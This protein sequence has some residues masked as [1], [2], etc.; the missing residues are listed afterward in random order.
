MTG[1]VRADVY[2]DGVLMASTA[3]EFYGG[4]TTVLSGLKIDWGRSTAVD[5]P[6]PSSL[7]LTFAQNQG[8]ADFLR[9]LAV[10]RRLDVTATALI[11]S[12][13]NQNTISGGD[14]EAPTVPPVATG[15]ATLELT[16]AQV[17]SGLQ[18]GLIRAVN[19]ALDAVMVFP[20]VPFSDDIT[21]W[22]AVPRMSSG[23][24]WSLGAWL[25][26]AWGTTVTVEPVLFSDPTGNYTRP[27]PS[28]TLTIQRTTT[29]TNL[30]TNPA[31]ATITGWVGPYPALGHLSNGLVC[32]QMVS[33]GLATPY[34][35]S[36]TAAPAALAGETYT[37]SALV[38]VVGDVAGAQY[39]FRAHTTPANTYFPSGA[40]TLT[41]GAGPNLQRVT[42]TS[43]INADTPAGTLNFSMVRSGTGAAGIQ[44]RMAQLT[45]EK[46][47][48]GGPYFDGN[49]PDSGGFRY[50]WTGAENASSSIQFTGA[51]EGW[52]EFVTPIPT[53]D[54]AWAGVM[55]TVHQIGPAWT[56]VS[57]SWSDQGATRRW[58][59]S[60][61]AYV[62]D[63][64]VLAP[65][66]GTVRSVLAFRGRV[67]DMEAKWV[68]TLAGGTTQV[69]VTAKDFTADLANNRIGDVPWL[70][71]A[72][73][74][75]VAR[76]LELA[77]TGV[78]AS[79]DASISS[80]PVSYRDVDSQ[81]AADLVT[82][83]AASVAAVAWPVVHDPG[84]ESYWVEDPRNR[85]PLYMLH[86]NTSTGQAEVVPNPVAPE[87]IGLTSSN[88]LEE[89][90][91]WTQDVADV[92]TRV[93]VTWLEQGVDED[94][95][96]ETTE[97]H[98]VTINAGL[99]SV[100][101]QRGFSLSTQLIS[102]DEAARVATSLLA[103]QHATEWRVAGVTWSIRYEEVMTRA[104]T[105]AA[106]DLLDGTVRIGHSLTI[107]DLP[108]WVPVS[109]AIVVYIEGGTYTFEDGDWVLELVA[110][111]SGI[112]GTV[113][114]AD[115]DPTWPW[116][117]FQ[118]LSWVDLIGVSA[119]PAPAELTTGKATP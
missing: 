88:V 33:S 29:R 91:R 16:T 46:G 113:T 7:A 59:D 38:E 57:G 76:I 93:D 119:A 94:G 63:V 114:W 66:E 12:G 118:N 8:Q 116:T 55:V 30:P 34:I 62:D 36:S 5:Q 56:D 4:R 78:T 92:A 41:M 85:P 73:G 82:E 15:N 105:V 47:T 61:R 64:T 19:A 31:P 84:G 117:N 87:A 39:I 102:P 24:A 108:S 115:V 110:S 70:V 48:T 60:N 58:I 28:V 32:A 100:L 45:I 11:P 3:A 21:A 2:L 80:T 109:D 22:D 52:H 25:W 9:S 43:T 79:V 51:D 77:G 42:V 20:P 71:E 69:D 107:S 95:H 101:G 49:T 40:V 75:R 23:E 99:E 54:G 83:L 35:F 111:S 44:M 74:V 97:R 98:Q 26:A 37:M 6:E 17:H 104:E 27:G 1:P 103:S 14:F 10:G 50:E 112:G 96:P 86:Q 18:A 53:Q 13:E 89:P 81:P 90:I 65:A 72:L 68:P 106:M 67:T